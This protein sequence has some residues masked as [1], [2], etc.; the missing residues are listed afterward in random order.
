MAKFQFFI[1]FSLALF[2][3][4]N[5]PNLDVCQLYFDT[6]W[7]FR[8][9]LDLTVDGWELTEVTLLTYL[10]WPTCFHLIHIYGVVGP[11]AVVVELDV[12]GHTLH[13]D[14]ARVTDRQREKDRQTDGRTETQGDV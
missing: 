3:T 4:S 11:A 2:P 8:P 14:L 12:A 10:P 6:E 9:A 5:E 13:L 7:D 1:F